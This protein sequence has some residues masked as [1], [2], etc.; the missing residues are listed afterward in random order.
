MYVCLVCYRS[1]SV[2][3]GPCPAC[4]IERQPLSEPQVRLELKREAERRLEKRMYGEYFGLSL[5]AFV[6]A[7][8]VFFVAYGPLF[9]FIPWLL[10]SLGLAWV[11]TRSYAWLR[12]RSALGLYADRQRRLRRELSGKEERLLLPAASAPPA[13]DPEGLDLEHVLT[14]LGA[15][16]DER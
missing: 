10:C 2:H 14:W 3:P 5:L 13:E 12:P 15:V 9:G 6:M 8:P 7:L 4:H 16:I 1:L 11:N